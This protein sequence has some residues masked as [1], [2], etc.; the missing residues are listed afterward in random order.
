[1][2]EKTLS[3]TLVFTSANGRARVEVGSQVDLT[4]QLDSGAFSVVSLPLSAL[5]TLDEVL[6]AM[7][8]DEDVQALIPAPEPEPTDPE[9]EP[10]P[11]VVP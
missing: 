6:T 5:P 7:I 3:T 8:A 2:V 4:Y 10:D 9:P 1:M 11:E